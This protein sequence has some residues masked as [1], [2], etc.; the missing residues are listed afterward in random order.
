MTNDEIAEDVLERLRGYAPA[1][2]VSSAPDLT[3]DQV[4]VVIIMSREWVDE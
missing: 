4:E 2:T 3:D 1:I